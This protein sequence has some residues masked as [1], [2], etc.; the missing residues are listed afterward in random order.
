MSKSRAAGAPAGLLARAPGRVNLIGDHTDYNAG[1]A[2]PLAIDLATE[3]TRHVDASGTLVVTSQG[4]PGRLTVTLGAPGRAAADEPAWGRLVRAV[5]AEVGPRA[6]SGGRVEISSSV[7]VG[8]GLSS[9]AAM[10]VA[11]ALALGA[12]AEPVALAEACQRAEAAAGSAVGLMDP[13]VSLAALA[14]TALFVD[15]AGPSFSPIPLPPTAG[16]V[17]VD[18][19]LPRRLEAS[20]YRTRRAECERAAARLG[21]PLGRAR[22]EDV[23]RLD[24]AVL[25]RRARHVVSECARVH[26]VVAALGEGDLVAAGRALRASHRSLAE[27]FEVS[28]PALDALVDQ[29]TACPGVYG[30]RMTGGGF[31]GSVVVLERPGALD[32][33]HWGGRAVRVRTAGGATVAALGQP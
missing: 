29:L 7:P 32:L 3:V 15:F 2:L 18:S 27:D 21:T 22:P 9:S 13:L 1:V 4:F 20:P 31:G 33:A 23:E 14:G 10:C 24:D 17:V 25:R 30:A 11:L 8:A 12:P 28:L 26:E 19:G 6:G 5:V 16:L